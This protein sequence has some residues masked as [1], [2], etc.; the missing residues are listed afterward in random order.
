MLKL[1]GGYIMNIIKK[2]WKSILIIFLTGILV[3]FFPLTNKD[4]F[5]FNKFNSIN[6]R[7]IKTLFSFEFLPALLAMVLSKIKLLKVISYTIAFTVLVLITKNIINKKNN[8]LSFIAIFLF[9]LLKDDL[10][11][12]S[13]ISP[14]GFSTNILPLIMTLFIVHLL[15]KDTLYKVP[16]MAVLMLGFVSSLFCITHSIV[17]FILLSTYLFKLILKKEKDKHFLFLYIGSA[18]GSIAI[19]IYNIINNNLLVSGLS[20]RLLHIL[21]PNI[22]S[23]DFIISLILISFLLFLSIKVY[24]SN[25]RFKR[26]LTVLS[27]LSV[28][29]YSLT[30]ILSTNDI[31]NYISFILFEASSFFIFINSNNKIHFKE[32]IKT[33]YLLKCLYMLI[34]LITNINISSILFIE[35][36]NIL[37]IITVID[38]IFPTNFMSY[39]WLF[40]SSFILILNTYMYRGTYIKSVEMNRYIKNHLECGMYEIYLPHR[41]YTSHKNHLLPNSK[42]EKEDYLTYLNK[43]FC[44]SNITKDIKY[45]IE[46]ENE[47]KLSFR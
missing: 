7:T 16:K 34:L 24:L 12:S 3:L 4:W 8:V 36:I 42:D 43:M 15:L 27:L 29:A 38:Y 25:G 30:R 17:I 33:F 31:L 5:W 23:M 21:I 20:E 41:Y 32:R 45:D 1:K 11:F 19:L 46:T 22:Y 6:L 2:Y 39:V 35:F 13:F 9:F 10:I 28:L 14:Y 44:S 37:V 40:I 18:I 26:I 47:K